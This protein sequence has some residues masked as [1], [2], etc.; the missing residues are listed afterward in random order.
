MQRG[1][2]P[3]RDAPLHGNPD[4]PER[5]AI[6]PLATLDGEGN[7]R[8][9]DNTST[10]S[11]TFWCT[12]SHAHHVLC[13]TRVPRCESRHPYSYA[14]RH[15]RCDKESYYCLPATTRMNEAQWREL[16]S[17]RA[18][19]VHWADGCDCAAHDLPNANSSKNMIMMQ[20]TMRSSEMS[21][22][23]CWTPR[24]D[25]IAACAS[26]AYASAGS[27]N[28]PMG[29][30]SN[31][32]ADLGIASPRDPSR[33]RVHTPRPACPVCCQVQREKRTKTC[34]RPPLGWRWN[35]AVIEGS[36]ASLSVCRRCPS[37]CLGRDR[38]N[39]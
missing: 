34:T 6:H 33:S 24:L 30:S 20:P 5:E 12:A 18:K 39:F 27:S 15:W 11:A 31:S 22:A 9:H 3:A 4:L 7:A 37:N 10:Y 1:F 2:L 17:V 8:A 38:S 35:G 16:V 21:G 25:C 23:L 13:W 36:T 19:D 28:T 32:R 29:C 14:P 26:C